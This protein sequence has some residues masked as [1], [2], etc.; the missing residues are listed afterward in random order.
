MYL[1]LQQKMYPRAQYDNIIDYLYH[2]KMN[3]IFNA[4]YFGSQGKYL[5]LLKIQ[6]QI[7][8]FF[9]RTNLLKKVVLCFFFFNFYIQI[10]IIIICILWNINVI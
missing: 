8:C 7:Q 10:N 4:L 5:K 6:C 2:C 3:T 9:S 1:P